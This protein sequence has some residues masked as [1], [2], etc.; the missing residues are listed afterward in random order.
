M[1]YSERKYY[2][3]FLKAWET[4][5]HRQRRQQLNHSHTR[6]QLQATGLSLIVSDH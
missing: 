5:L 2:N 6:T 4:E 1:A 3:V